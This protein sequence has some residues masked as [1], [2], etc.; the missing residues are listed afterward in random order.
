MRLKK[1]N[2][3]ITESQ[4]MS[5]LHNNSYWTKER[6]QEEANKYETRTEFS[7]NNT[8]AYIKTLKNNLLDELFKNHTN[9]GYSKK[10]KISG[11]WSDE[12]L[13]EE[14]NKYE[15]R[16]E[17]N[18]NN[19]AAY[20]KALKMNILDKLFKN[21]TN[22]GYINK[23]EWKENSYV[24]YVYELEDFN[25]CYIGLT[26]NIIRRDK[27]HLFNIKSKLSSFCKENDLSLPKYK[28]LEQN[29]KS[30]EAQKQEKYWLNYY[31]D[32]GWKMF[33]SI[34]A[35]GLGSLSKKWT[36]KELQKEAD[37]YKTRV[38]FKKN[39]YAAYI[40]SY[41]IKIMNE[42][43][44]NHTN[45]GYS[46]KQKVKGYW[47]EERLKEEANKYKNRA[48]FYKSNA[49]AYYKALK[50]NIIDELFKKN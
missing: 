13:Q 1:Y 38:E 6:L 48:E 16:T 37:K 29:L 33:N 43:F 31:K 36:K 20:G 7:K 4:K 34:E 50:L 30:N 41:K 17:F 35:G 21:H 3:Y 46:D 12:R 11:Y 49:S 22:N 19:A 9:N 39:N 24:I 40:A 45:N 47:T 23:E 26:N 15:T 28:I 42:L 44:K 2:Q 32:N 27:E 25:I 5:S 10:Q 8:Y 18:K 14:A